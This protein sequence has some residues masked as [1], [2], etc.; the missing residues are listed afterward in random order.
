MKHYQLLVDSILHPKKLAA[1]RLLPIGKVI[2]YVFLLITFITVISFSKFLTGMG[3]GGES[4][5]LEGLSEYLDDIKWLLYPF[6]FVFLFIITS[7]LTF[8][9][10]SIYGFVGV[11]LLKMMGHRGEY[12]HIW[13]TTALA[14]TL[15][16]ILSNSLSF[17]SLNG[18]IV[19][20]ISIAITIAYIAVAVTKYPKIKK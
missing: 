5:Q 12:R 16:T 18:S 19:T 10:I 11:I 7:F 4:M 1:Y 20:V 14:I 17:T 8:L 3:S 6:A 9:R 2:Q 13:R 15:A